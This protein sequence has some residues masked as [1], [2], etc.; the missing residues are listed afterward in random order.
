MTAS[1]S[2]APSPSASPSSRSTNFSPKASLWW[3][4]DD[5]WSTKLSFGQACAL[6]DGGGALPD[7]LD[8]PDLRHSQPVP[9]ARV[10]AVASSSPSSGRPGTR[11]SASSLFEE[12]T[13]NALIQQTQLINNVFT[14]TWQNVGLIRN[15]GFEL[16]GELKDVFVPG[17]TLSTA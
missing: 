17:L 14:T 1:T 6:S 8:R 2:R 4:I 12:D 3:Q 10:G 7:R 5:E 11:G 13:S 16:V 15:R 9:A